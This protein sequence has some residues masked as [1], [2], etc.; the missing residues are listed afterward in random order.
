MTERPDQQPA[1]PAEE[2]ETPAA[3]PQESGGPK[4][5]E[6]TRYGDWESNGVCWDF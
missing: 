5:L 1:A 3:R 2:P 6:P 4:G